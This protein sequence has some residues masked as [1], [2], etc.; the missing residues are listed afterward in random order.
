MAAEYDTKA[1]LL[2][3]M[4][5]GENK[6]C[7]ECKLPSPQWCSLSYGTTLCLTCSGTHRSLGVHLSFVRSLTMDKWT[8]TQINRMLKGG[9]QKAR[10]FF[11]AN[12]EKWK[13][14]NLNEKYNTHTAAMYRDKLLADAEDRPWIPSDT[15]VSSSNTSTFNSVSQSSSSSSSSLR[16]PRTNGGGGGGSSGISSNDSGGRAGTISQKQQNETYFAKMGSENSLRSTDLPPSQGGRYSGFG[17]QPQPQSQSHSGGGGGGGV[18]A[19]SSRALPG[20]DDLRDDPVGALGKGW[21]FLGAALGAVGKTVNESVIQPGLEKAHDPNLQSQFSTFFQSASTTFSTAA[22]NSGQ[23]L[24]SGLESS[25]NFLKKDLGLNVGDLGSGFIES[26]FSGRAGVGGGAREGYGKVG[27]EFAPN[28]LNEREQP[29]GQ[30][31]FFEDQLSTGNSTP[32]MIKT[33]NEEGGGGFRDMPT[34]TT[35]T[36]ST[37]S[38]QRRSISPIQPPPKVEGDWNSLAP[39]VAAARAAAAAAN[40][41]NANKSE[42]KKKES[43]GWDDFED[44]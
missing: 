41:A 29:G 6:H 43:D 34:S 30:G 28:G 3:W 9:N 32:Q 5:E 12:G 13:Q 11:E 35:T 16:K 37:S 1:V 8:P 7:S 17:S 22:K 26:R 15:P 18:G 23:V 14:E 19:L 42:G 38:H 31:D 21:G 33:R 24:S 25:S 44:F 27:E 40:A 39:K 2:D 36:T 10:E 4:K 20:L